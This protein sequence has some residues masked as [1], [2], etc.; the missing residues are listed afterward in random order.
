M[1][2]RHAPRL[3][4]PI[5]PLFPA[6]ELENPVNKSELIDHLAAHG[7]AAGLPKRAIADVLDGLAE[8]AT[9]ALLADGGEVTLPGIGKLVVKTREARTGRN[10]ATGKELSI[11]AKRTPAFRPAKAFK[12]AIA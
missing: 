7:P 5:T 8:A 10:P 2:L 4:Q 11:P 12:A 1:L 6:H 3:P 9:H